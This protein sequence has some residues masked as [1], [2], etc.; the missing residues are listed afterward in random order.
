M[1]QYH[2]YD[3]ERDHGHDDERFGIGQK[4][5]RQQGENH[6]HRDREPTIER[7]QVIELL[8]L[9]ATKGVAQL[10]VLSGEFGKDRI[11]KN[12]IGFPAGNDGPIHLCDHGDHTLAIPAA[13]GWRRY[14][15]VQRGNLAQRDFR[16][17]GGSDQNPSTSVMEL[18][19]SAG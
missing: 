18:R 17:L 19:S 10:G 7:P 9:F 8:L 11:D 5:N 16:S 6:E 2:A 1:A 13:D 14:A 3:T 12:S 4:R 15:R